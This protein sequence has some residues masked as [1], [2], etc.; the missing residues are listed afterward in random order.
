MTKHDIPEA[1]RVLKAGGLIIYPTDTLYALGA[2]IFNEAAV[3]SVFHT[4]KRPFTIPLPVAVASVSAMETIAY[5][6]SAA[7]ALGHRFLPGTLTI[8]L[9]KKP[10]IPPIVTSG[11]DSIGL[12]I[13]NNPVA[14]DLLARFGPLT[15]TS[16]NLHSEKTLGVISDIRMQLG[17]PH[18][19]GLDDGRLTGQPSTTVDLTVS[20]PRVVRRGPITEAQ[21]LEVIAHG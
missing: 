20:P 3:R 14:L 11:Q 4:K 17:T 18:L 16:A 5:M 19:L 2:D 15:V 1:L 21:I 8:I 7:F 10:A 6:N 13:P 9:K 12:R